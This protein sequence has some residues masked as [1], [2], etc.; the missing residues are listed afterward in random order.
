MCRRKELQIPAQKSKDPPYTRISV[1]FLFWCVIKAGSSIT[2]PLKIYPLSQPSA[3]NPVIVSY[4]QKTQTHHCFSTLIIPFYAKCFISIFTLIISLM[5]PRILHHKHPYDHYSSSRT[6]MEIS[7]LSESCMIL[8]QAWDSD[9]DPL[10]PIPR[11]FSCTTL[12][13]QSFL[14]GLLCS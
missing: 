2:V 7:N 5:H 1:K 6:S 8:E 13:L 3:L 14:G 10:T 4:T 9:A 12:P 11:L